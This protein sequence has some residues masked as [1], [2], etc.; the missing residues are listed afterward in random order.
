MRARLTLSPDREEGERKGGREAER[1]AEREEEEERGG[2]GGFH[3]MSCK[4][5]MN[6]D[7]QC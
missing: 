7:R 3:H 5:A 4:H 1:E 6:E 2:R